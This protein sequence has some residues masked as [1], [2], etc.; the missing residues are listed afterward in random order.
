MRTERPSADAL[1][2]RLQQQE[3]ARLRIYIGAA[4]GVGKTYEMLQEAHA[5][6]ARGLDVVVGYVETYGRR[7]TDAQIKDLEI[8]TRRPIEYRGVMMEEMDVDAILRRKP[9]VV[10]VDE[11]AHTNVR[12]S[13]HEKSRFVCHGCPSRAARIRAGG[14]LPCPPNWAGPRRSTS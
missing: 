9:Q 14:R 10:L 12:A 7:D 8:V 1:L 2:A 6:R 5:L 3:R 13:R 11:L 4:P